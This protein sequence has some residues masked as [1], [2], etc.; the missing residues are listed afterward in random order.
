MLSWDDLRLPDDSEIKEMVKLTEQSFEE[1]ASGFSTGLEYRPGN[2]SSAEHILP[3]VKL[4]AKII[5]ILY[6]CKK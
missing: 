5:F 1:G 3:Y 6:T 4:L 2:Q